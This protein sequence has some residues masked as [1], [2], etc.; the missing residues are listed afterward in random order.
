MHAAVADSH[1]IQS[2][3]TEKLQ[4]CA[5]LKFGLTTKWRL[6]TACIMPLQLSTER[7]V[8]DRLQES[9]KL[10]DLRPDLYIIMQKAVILSAG[11]SVRKF[12][13]ER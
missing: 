12:L 11:R 3:V 5:D 10:P 2:T 9:V 4:K 7:I 1:S 8:T 13:A 6:K